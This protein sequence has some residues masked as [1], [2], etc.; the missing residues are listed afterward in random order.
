MSDP[1]ADPATPTPSG[2]RSGRTRFVFVD[3]EAT[4]LD[5]ERHELTEVSWI[6]RFEDGR[7]EE[8]QFFP[9]HTIDGADADAL[10]L[11]RYDDRIAP[12]DKTPASEWLTLFLEDAQDAVLV[13]AVPDFDAQHLERMCRKLGLEP[14]WDHHLLDV[15]TLAL[16]LIAPGPEAPRSLAKTCLA[17]GIPHDK[18]QAHGAL[19]D[20]RQARLAFDRIWQLLAELRAT[21]A[22]LPP[23]VPRDNGRNGNGNGNGAGAVDPGVAK[24]MAATPADPDA[25]D[26]RAE[27]DAHTPR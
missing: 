6:V 17:L 15:E 19:Y 20:A 26:Q 2:R 4:G 18:D 13:G 16:P 5:H 21:G 24:Q 23:P 11:T 22:P 8:R 1:S 9:Q 27:Q 7:E 14:T 12:Q 25:P 3:T 10:T